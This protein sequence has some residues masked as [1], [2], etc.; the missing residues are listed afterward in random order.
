MVLKARRPQEL[1]I[2]QLQHW[3]R[4]F[5]AGFERN[6]WV[7]CPKDTQSVKARGWGEPWNVAGS[8]PRSKPEGGGALGPTP[9]PLPAPP[10]WA[11]PCPWAHPHNGCPACS[12]P[13]RCPWR[14]ACVYFTRGRALGRVD[15]EGAGK[16]GSAGRPPG[17]WLQTRGE[18][19]ARALPWL[20]QSPRSMSSKPCPPWS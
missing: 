14:P 10:P 19:G 7:P 13:S 9:H 15:Q 11:G 18:H 1:P 8:A 20:G 16:D 5:R 12:R 17:P 2:F 6:T 3:D 4:I